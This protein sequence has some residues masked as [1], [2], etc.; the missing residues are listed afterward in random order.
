M[1]NPDAPND[2]DETGLAGALR[3]DDLL[4]PELD[5]TFALGTRFAFAQG[6]TGRSFSHQKL[7]PRQASDLAR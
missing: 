5:N 3:L 4:Y 2:Y 7:W 6:I 1:T